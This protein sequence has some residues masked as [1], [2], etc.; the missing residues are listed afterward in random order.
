MHL[1]IIMLVAGVVCA[2]EP[3]QP[4]AEKPDAAR[5]VS[6]LGHRE[7]AE[8]DKA[9]NALKA[10]GSAAKPALEE[11]A[12]SANLEISTRCKMLLKD[13]GGEAPQPLKEVEAEVPMPSTAPD[14]FPRMEDFKNVQEFLEAWQKHS[15]AMVK[16]LMEGQEGFPMPGHRFDV[17]VGP[18]GSSQSVQLRDGERVEIERKD[19]S[20]R[21]LLQKL[22]AK[23]AP[24]GEQQVFEA[25]SDE[26]F[27]AKYP[28]VAKAYLTEVPLKI[29]GYRSWPLRGRSGLKP[30]PPLQPVL[31][32]SGP[33]LGITLESAS[34]DLC[35]HVDVPQGTQRI[36]SVQPGSLA[37]R[38][39][40]KVQDLLL[41]LDGHAILDV[42]DVRSGMSKADAPPEIQLE[43]MRRGV[44]M[45]LKGMRKS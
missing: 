1:M 37:E 8:R 25:A 26:E 13:L 34:A 32:P 12:K 3:V 35:A 29:D 5:L 21:L 19:G 33:L 18:H 22:D 9:T 42:R 27:R 43:V 31:P 14:A 11:G 28:E 2:Q 10:L 4:A 44:R 30:I 23:G 38:L 7:F 24:L 6:E 15:D 40:V 36:T 45:T 17:K 16:R 20:V 39:G 41:A